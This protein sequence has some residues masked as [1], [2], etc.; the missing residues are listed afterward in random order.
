M[1]EC[2]LNLNDV[3]FSFSKRRTEPVDQR[4]MINEYKNKVLTLKQICIRKIRYSVGFLTQENLEQLRLPPR[5]Q[6]EISLVNLRN[7][8]LRQLTSEEP[9][10]IES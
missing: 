5:L 10:N 1:A 8:V 7:L 6:K 2:G 3:N 9:P 4:K